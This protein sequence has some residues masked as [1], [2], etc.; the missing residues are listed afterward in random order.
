MTTIAVC[1]D[2]PKAVEIIR[3]S[4]I[5]TFHQYAEETDIRC[6][7]S[8]TA[9]I[10]EIIHGTKYDL[11]FLDIDMP[12]I[13]GIDIGVQMRR[14]QHNE[15]LI[16][17]TN[18]S[19]MV[20][21]SF[22]AQ[23][24][25]FIRKSEYAHEIPE[26]I[27][28]YRQLA[29]EKETRCIVIHATARE[30]SIHPEEVIYIEALRK[31]QFIHTV[32]DAYETRSRFSELIAQFAPYGMIQIHKSYLV[33]YHFIKSIDPEGVL[34]DSGI[35]LPVSRLRLDEVRK[36]YHHWILQEPAG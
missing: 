3:R 2:E 23:P 19:E 10:R 36:A 29:S 9:F 1:D 7:A 31:S 34:L 33:N 5:N 30:V 15:P 28:A 24:F 4:L 6:Y 20:Y 35:L 11:V 14:Y 32:R 18:R 8:S 26:V 12:D 21:E 27:A 13:N 17:V 25:R 22:K 16:Y